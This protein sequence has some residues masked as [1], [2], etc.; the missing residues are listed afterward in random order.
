MIDNTDLILPLLDFSDKDT[1][2]FAQVLKRGNNVSGPAQRWS[3]I[4][5]KDRLV[6]DLGL[7]EE[8]ADKWDARVYISLI[9]RSLKKFTIEVCSTYLERIKTESWSGANYRIPRSVALKPE[10]EK[11][12]LWL[13]DIDNPEFKEPIEDWVKKENI[14]LVAEIP[15]FH[16]YH[17]IVNPFN[18]RKY[19]DSPDLEVELFDGELYFGIKKDCNT[20]LYG[21]S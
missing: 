5:T 21:Q 16:G 3:G 10:T 15:T 4:I 8:I 13:F 12:G 20:I 7:A 14:K 2:Y 1:Y 17:F 11:R 6:Q 18:P 9:P 19:T